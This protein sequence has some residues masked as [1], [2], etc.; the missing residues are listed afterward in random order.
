MAKSLRASRNKTNKSHLR[1]KV[2]QPVEDARIERL[3]AKLLELASKPKEEV[4]GPDAD[5]EEKPAQGGPDVTEETH[6]PG[7]PAEEMDIDR[8]PVKSK[9]RS[10]RAKGV[11]KR[12]AKVVFAVGKQHGKRRSGKGY[13][14][15]G[16][17]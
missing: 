17:G 9:P 4:K 16:V 10:S 13:Q 14:G 2:H 6:S 8:K 1:A 11:K 15:P 7:L 5:T 3:S 12:R